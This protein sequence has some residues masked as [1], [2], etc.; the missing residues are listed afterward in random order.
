MQKIE[1]LS[2]AGD[3]EKLRTVIHYGADAVYLGGKAFNLRAASNNFSRDELSE[4][5]EYAHQFGKRVY[6]TLNILAHNKEIAALPQFVKHLESIGVDGVIVADLGVFSVVRENSSLP[7][8]ISTQASSTNWQTVKMWQTMGAKRVVLA[9]ECTLKEIKEIRDR[10][11]D[12]ELEVFVH[13]A[14]CMAYS[15]RCMISQYMTERDGNRGACAN[16]CRWKYSVMEETR[17]GE[18]FPVYEDET[19]SYLYNSKDLC[20]IEFIEQ[21]L[22]AGVN[23]L[24]IEGRMK[25]VFYGGSVTRVYRDALDSYLSG[26]YQYQPEWLESL[27]C[28]SN[29]G[30]TSGF[31]LGKLDKNS[32]NFEGGYE[33]TKEFVGTVLEILP[34]GKVLLDI[35]GR[36]IQSGE[37]LEVVLRSGAPR[38]FVMPEMRHPE[39]LEIKQLA[40]PGQRVI[41]NDPG[42]EWRVFDMIQRP[43]LRSEVAA[44]EGDEAAVNSRSCSTECEATAD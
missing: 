6:V 36:R 14:M 15:G 1:L 13:G 19:G 23:G 16:A 31:F 3:M 22:A 12:I 39:T 38:S 24:K 33:R 17:P 25:T 5:V 2:P 43:M 4:A 29:R 34:E 44:E 26:S 20:T 40:Q 8:H 21:I 32:Q 41:I 35:R 11:P 10:V 9:R 27:K 7:I 28:V 37:L 42:V 18:Y 30:Y